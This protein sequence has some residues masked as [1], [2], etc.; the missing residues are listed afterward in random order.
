MNDEQEELEE[1]IVCKKPTIVTPAIKTAAAA[2]AKHDTLPIGAPALTSVA[3]A[4]AGLATAPRSHGTVTPPLR[5]VSTSSIKSSP[6]SE[7]NTFDLDLSI[8][9]EQ[10]LYKSRSSDTP[11]DPAIMA[12]P[13]DYDD[14][15]PAQLPVRATP[16]GVAPAVPATTVAVSNSVTA[17]ISN[18]PKP[19]YRVNRPKVTYTR[20]N[21][22]FKR[23][24]DE[25]ES[26]D[27]IEIHNNKQARTG[28]SVSPGAERRSV[29]S[30]GGEDS[31]TV[32]ELMRL[33]AAAEFGLRRRAGS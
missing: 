15:P 2:V 21:K 19:A 27:G 26:M 30:V 13:V 29:G 17:A 14:E 22:N 33:G 7:P 25:D 8:L 24:A 6:L 12:P 32:E 4:A 31:P 23:K 16:N 1:V 10:L 5:T 11:D 20:T 18:Y 28:T 9:D 3:L